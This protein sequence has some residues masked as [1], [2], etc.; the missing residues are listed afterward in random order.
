[1]KL[2]IVIAIGALL[3]GCSTF[4]TPVHKHEYSIV[5]PDSCIKWKFAGGGHWHCS[6]HPLT[7][8]YIESLEC[9]NKTCEWKID[10]ETRVLFRWEMLNLKGGESEMG[11]SHVH[12]Q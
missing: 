5:T 11:Y 1:M 10:W 6:H 9:V 12:K 4:E 3:L 8:E 7:R 2:G